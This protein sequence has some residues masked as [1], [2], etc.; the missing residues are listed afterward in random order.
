M[1]MQQ[2]LFDAKEGC[3]RMLVDW[4]KKKIRRAERAG[5]FVREK[6]SFTFNPR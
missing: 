5:G 1:A 3:D 4:K 2:N 6:K